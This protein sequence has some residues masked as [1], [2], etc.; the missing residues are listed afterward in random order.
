M[1]LR[2][3]LVLISCAV[4]AQSPPDLAAGKVLFET[5][6]A[7]CHGIGGKGSRG[8]GL[9]HAKLAKAPD[10]EALKKLIENGIEPEMPSF[11]YLAF[12]D[13]APLVAYVRS[14][15]RMVPEPVTGNAERGATVYARNKCYACH[16]VAGEG[17]GFGPELTEISFR[18]SPGYL[19][20]AIIAP[21]AA[22]PENFLLVEAKTKAGQ[23]I[24][25]IRANEDP[26]TI[27]I[28][29]STGSFHSLRKDNLATLNKLRG[30][31]PMPAYK[32]PAADLDDLIAYLA[33]LGAK[34]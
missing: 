3:V 16:I 28:K 21:E 23:S 2:P 9:N 27:Q 30:K 22:L 10:D 4:Y 14:L 25:G 20:Q 12:E 26:F 11:W 29:D 24:R 8:P 5:H 19:R 15:G 18:R 34:P 1:M 33:S 17:S 31:S 32:L 13:T 6:C 7:L